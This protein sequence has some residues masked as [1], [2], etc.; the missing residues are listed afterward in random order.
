MKEE[1]LEAACWHLQH[2]MD[3]SAQR[4]LSRSLTLI[5]F[6]ARYKHLVRMYQLEELKREYSRR[7]R[8]DTQT[9]INMQRSKSPKKPVIQ[10]GQGYYDNAPTSLNEDESKH[11][12]Y[13]FLKFAIA[14]EKSTRCA[15]NSKIRMGFDFIH[16]TAINRARKDLIHQLEEE[17]GNEE[18]QEVESFNLR[19]EN[20][21]G[22]SPYDHKRIGVKATKKLFDETYNR[23]HSKSLSNS[24]YHPNYYAPQE[25]LSVNQGYKN[26]AVPKV[27]KVRTPR[28][29]HNKSSTLTESIVSK[30]NNQRNITRSQQGK[31]GVPSDDNYKVVTMIVKPNER[32]NRR[33]YNNINSI[34]QVES[35]PNNYQMNG[36]Y[37][38]MYPTSS[39][40]I[41]LRVDKVMKPKYNSKNQNRP[42][43]VGQRKSVNPSRSKSKKRY[44]DIDDI[45][46]ENISPRNGPES[47]LSSS[48]LS[49]S[50]A[51]GVKHMYKKDYSIKNMR[52]QSNS[53]SNRAKDKSYD[54]IH[55]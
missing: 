25:K 9:A 15:Y 48:R 12:Y 14:L 1:A 52:P 2:I 11:R 17:V 20:D 28:K 50:N 3:V 5:G 36:F 8:N 23:G 55:L 49:A 47:A 7:I 34:Q 30:K 16:Y 44:N 6:A 45:G 21:L 32:N 40:N 35:L 54:S 39:N 4:E 41:N 24:K 38:N 27:K 51:R 53:Y 33:G 10:D 46:R 26:Y 22:S 29:S 31:V 13:R 19:R 42:R 37:Q 43:G 18:Y